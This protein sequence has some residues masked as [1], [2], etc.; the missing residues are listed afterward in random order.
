MKPRAY[1][2]DNLAQGSVPS[3]ADLPERG[4]A[5]RSSGEL[6]AESCHHERTDQRRS[7]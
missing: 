1:L 6:T 5:V 4:R 3:N 2:S 7:V